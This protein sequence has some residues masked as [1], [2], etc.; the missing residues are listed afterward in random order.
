MPLVGADIGKTYEASCESAASFLLTL[1]VCK[2]RE[3]QSASL[4]WRRKWHTSVD[5]AAEVQQAEQDLCQ[6]MV[7]CA[8]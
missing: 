6:S 1:L 7:Q 2:A 3:R 4:V 8:Q 5:G